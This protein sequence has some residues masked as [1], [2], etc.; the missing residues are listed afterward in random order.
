MLSNPWL[1]SRGRCLLQIVWFTV[2]LSI[3]YFV[4]RQCEGRRLNSGRTPDWNPRCRRRMR[5]YF[6]G[7]FLGLAVNGDEKTAHGWREHWRFAENQ[8]V[9]G[10]MR[11]KQ[12][13]PVDI[14]FDSNNGG[15]TGERTCGSGKDGLSVGRH[16]S[17]LR[18]APWCAVASTL[19]LG[20]RW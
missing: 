18:V 19:G 2:P 12:P 16:K 8:E 13:A 1:K 9:G 17:R 11:G 5:Q 14:E 4:A 6:D 10:G 20:A 7:G 3:F 15:I